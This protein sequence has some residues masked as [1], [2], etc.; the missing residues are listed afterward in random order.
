[1][2]TANL[3]ALTVLALWVAAI[4]IW[5]IYVTVQTLRQLEVANVL[6]ANLYAATMEYDEDWDEDADESDDAQD[7]R[8]AAR[9]N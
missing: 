3:I 1:M 8:E 6:L 5:H 7:E 9:W 4:S 2:E